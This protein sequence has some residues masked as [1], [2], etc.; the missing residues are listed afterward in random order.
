MLEKARERVASVNSGKIRTIQG[1]FR[2]I[3]LPEQG[4][5]VIVATAVLHH[6]RHDKDWESAFSKLYNLTALGGS[7]WITDLVSHD[8]EA[9]KFLMWDA[10]AKS[11]LQAVL[12]F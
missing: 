4:Y 2:E 10:P 5:D 7:V 12:E 11:L 6:L 3:T 9:V 8:T 1:D